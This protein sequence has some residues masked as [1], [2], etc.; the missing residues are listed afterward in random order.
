M[1]GEQ[2]AVGTISVKLADMPSRQYIF[3]KTKVYPAP[4][5][6]AAKAP[7]SAPRGYTTSIPDDVEAYKLS[8]RKSKVYRSPTEPPKVKQIPLKRKFRSTYLSKFWTAIK[9]HFRAVKQDMLPQQTPQDP[10][11]DVRIPPLV[12]CVCCLPKN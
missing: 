12:A 10:N 3:G 11:G 6:D 8:I 4:L 5:L 2:S 7:W 9:D 1:E